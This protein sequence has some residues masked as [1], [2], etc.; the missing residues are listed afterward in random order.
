MPVKEL[1]PAFEKLDGHPAL[2]TYQTVLGGS[3]NEWTLVILIDNY[4]HIDKGPLLSQ[5]V[6]PEKAAKV[7]ARFNERIVDED[8][9]I[10]DYLPEFSFRRR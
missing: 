2:L 3:P 7:E 5:A 6:G 1:I 9:A 10:L 4:A 8:L